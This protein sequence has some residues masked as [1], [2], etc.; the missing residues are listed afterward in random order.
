M[1]GMSLET[2]DEVQSLIRRRQREESRFVWSLIW[3]EARV[4]SS[5]IAG[6]AMLGRIKLNMQ[7]E[8]VLG[9][10]CLVILKFEHRTKPQ[11]GSLETPQFR[12]S[13]RSSTS[14]SDS[15]GSGSG[16]LGITTRER[17]KARRDRDEK[18]RDRERRTEKSPERERSPCRRG[19]E[20][21]SRVSEK[22][23]ST[24][25]DAQK[26]PKSSVRTQRP[27]TSRAELADENNQNTHTR[28]RSV[29]RSSQLNTLAQHSYVV[30]RNAANQPYVAAPPV[31]SRPVD[32]YS[33]YQP[34]RRGSL[35]PDYPG[36]TTM[37]PNHV[38]Y[39]HHPHLAHVPGYPGN[40][41]P[42]NPFSTE[43]Q[44]RERHASPTRRD[45]YPG[46]RWDFEAREE[47]VGRR[48]R[49]RLSSRRRSTVDSDVSF[50]NPVSR[51]EEMEYREPDIEVRDRQRSKG[52]DVVRSHSPARHRRAYWEDE[53]RL[54]NDTALDVRH[55]HYRD[56][57]YNR[58]DIETP[59]WSRG[60]EKPLRSDSFD[61]S[62]P[63]APR[64]DI[65]I[66]RST[67]YGETPAY[68]ASITDRYAD[69]GPI[70]VEEIFRP[71]THRTRSR[72]RGMVS[73]ITPSA[74]Q[75]AK[76]TD[77]VVSDEEEEQEDDLSRRV[78]AHAITPCA[79]ASEQDE[80]EKKRRTIQMNV[81]PR[82]DSS[83]QKKTRFEDDEN[84]ESSASLRVDTWLERTRD[85]QDD[86]KRHE[87]AERLRDKLA[88]P[89]E[90]DSD[91]ASV[92][93]D[94][95]ADWTP[96]LDAQ[97]MSYEPHR[98]SAID[99]NSDRA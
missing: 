86:T 14:S 91:E 53:L 26:W 4:H 75:A 42:P 60:P 95:S 90:K 62:Y 82:K 96:I 21:S 10:S 8:G 64:R 23:E 56:S 6:K 3:L 36:D 78:L 43:G 71:A 66:E 44:V 61:A 94:K 63:V 49:E 77:D 12:H 1:Q 85:E 28:S 2:M 40:P 84:K 51:Y 16:Y 92:E 27:S 46:H 15:S 29:R 93:E 48:G 13:R 87:L 30:R 69:F 79:N 58:Y 9:E 83:V 72:S 31:S 97:A 38:H 57:D 41:L 99:E 89:I 50:A 54:G 76:I 35:V 47:P 17:S 55:V 74:S 5:P 81:Q 22:P 25:D 45:P 68:K 70:T 20:D 67:S 65:R 24:P 37:N 7:L 18:P 33:S 52:D 34:A 39:R 73:A 32:Y 98:L 11:S 88:T 59:H 80:A 19:S